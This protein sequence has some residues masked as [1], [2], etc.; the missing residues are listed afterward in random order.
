[1]NFNL[2]PCGKNRYRLSPYGDM[3][4]EAL[5]FLSPKLKAQFGESEALKQLAD[6]AS[7]PGVV[8]PVIGMPDIHTGF[9]L[10]IGGVMAT[11]SKTG[12]VSAGAVGM[13]IN[14]GVRLLRTN[15]E[16][17]SLTTGKLEKLLAAIEKRVPSGV[18]KSSLYR[19]F[20]EAD[21][22]A[23]THQGA[24]YFIRRGYGF[25]EDEASIE[26][27][28]ALPGADLKA[29]SQQARERADQLATIGGGNH[30]I[31]IGEVEKVFLPEVASVMG[32]QEGQVT[33]LIHTGSRGFGHQ[34]CTDYSARMA[35]AA[36]KYGI[37]LPSK[38]LAAAPI[39]SPE[40]RQY[41][42]A[43]ACAANFAFANRQLIT[44]LVREAFEEVLKL[45]LEEIGLELVYD[46]AH[47]I[48]KF[49]EHKGRTLLVHRKGA[50][51]A[52]PAGHKEN[53][54][55]YLATGHP[56]IIPG[57]MGTASYVVIGT[58]R[59][60][61]TFNSVNHGAGR[62][63]S[64]KKAKSSLSPEELQESLKGVLLRAK[65]LRSLLDE[66]PVAYKDI[67]EV[68]GTLVD[69]GLTKPVARLKPLAVIKGEGDEG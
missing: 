38:G 40:G 2:E 8:S 60:G 16:A 47:N 5:V 6:A 53:P 69:A 52:L 43:M 50:T 21:L 34:I 22:E 62:I 28:G 61:E 54:A 49:E 23:V 67:D 63:M 26:A 56:A 51:R 59:I 12:V 3:Q 55:R 48:A 35:Q 33:I 18:G 58:E 20:R 17:K 44:F 4:V 15:L 29:V 31:E 36:S 68:V 66:A 64:R 37:R 45:S 19:E 25:P 13:D 11:D 24:A 32:L 46:V 41:L 57:S 42:A 30:F 7:L 65:N 10:P 14:C 1:M 9:G 39:D 27:G